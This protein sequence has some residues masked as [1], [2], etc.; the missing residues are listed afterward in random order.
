MHLT[1][2]YETQD[3]LEMAKIAESENNDFSLQIVIIDMD[4]IFK[5]DGEWDIRSE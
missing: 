3:Q 1:L 4:Y 2:I 5:D